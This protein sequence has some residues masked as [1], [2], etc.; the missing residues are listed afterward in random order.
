[1]TATEHF[2]S[3]GSTAFSSASF[4]CLGLGGLIKVDTGNSSG[5]FTVKLYSLA[6]SSTSAS[7]FLTLSRAANTSDL[8]PICESPYIDKHAVSVQMVS[9]TGT[10]SISEI[11]KK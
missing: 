10:I 2:D 5:T 8:I 4:Y 9:G 7:A 6:G 11:W 1:V 3:A